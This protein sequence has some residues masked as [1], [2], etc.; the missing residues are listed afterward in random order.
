MK[1]ATPMSLIGPAY[2]EAKLQ[3]LRVAAFAAAPGILV[4]GICV[5]RTATTLQTR[6]YIGTHILAAA[7]AGQH[8]EYSVSQL[9]SE[10]ANR[11]TG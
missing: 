5:R 11:Q 8:R 2:Q 4:T 1:M 10:P 3:G 6:T 7:S 9:A